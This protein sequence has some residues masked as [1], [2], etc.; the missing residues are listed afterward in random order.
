MDNDKLRVLNHLLLNV[1]SSDVSTIFED[2]C[3]ELKSLIPYRYSLTSYADNRGSHFET[4]RYDSADL[5]S[6]YLESYRNKYAAMDFLTWRD[7]QPVRG[8]Y[9]ESDLVSPETLHK[10]VIY[11]EWLKPLDCAYTISAVSVESGIIYGSFALMRN[12]ADGNFTQEELD[13]LSI[14]NDHVSQRLGQLC[15]MGIGRQ[16]FE[17][18]I[19]R[20]QSTYGLTKRELEIVEYMKT[21]ASRSAIAGR[22]Y[23]TPNTL[24]KHIANIYRKMNVKNESELFSLVNAPLP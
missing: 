23:I 19:D 20:L 5:P 17:T 1:H 22:L 16:V 2:V 13:I 7:A 6:A 14:A 3:R 9:R 10:S 21:G 4:F 8:V 18:G 15:P 24:K 11:I 12:E